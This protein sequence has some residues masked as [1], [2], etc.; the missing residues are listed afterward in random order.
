MEKYRS[1]PQLF[2]KQVEA[3]KNHIALRRKYMG[4]WN[5]VTW[6][7]YGSSVTKTAAGL[8]SYGI[9]HG[10]KVAI[11][12]DNR[13]EWIISH[14]AA[15]SIGCVTCGIYPTSA[16]DQIEYIANHSEAKIIFIENEEQIDKV[17]AIKKK[18]TPKNNCCLGS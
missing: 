17:L 2:F 15:M 13:P 12:G 11:L 8:L 4:I 16:P 3:R 9:E 14:L 7:E 6:T 18:Y 10:D 5:P 1:F